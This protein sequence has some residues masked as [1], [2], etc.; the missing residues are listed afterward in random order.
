MNQLNPNVSTKE[1]DF[2]HV[3]QPIINLT[4]NTVHGYE[5]LIRSQHF[6]NPER[7][8]EYARQ[9]N[10]LAN[11][12]SGS[13]FEAFRTFMK[14][15][16]SINHLN[17]FVNIFPSTL[18]DSSFYSFLKK[19][20]SLMDMKT[21]HVVFEIN[22]A[23]K[24]TDFSAVKEGIQAIRNE[25]FRI[26]LDDIGKGESTLRAILEIQPDIAKIDRYFAGDLAM[27]PEK[28]KALKLMLMLFDNGTEVIVEGFECEDDLETAR[29]LG[30]VYGQGYFLGKPKPI[31][32]YMSVAYPT[33]YRKF[34]RLQ[35][36]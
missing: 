1:I 12:D 13:I 20:K 27:S 29:E 31:K 21:G 32:D 4:T 9:K 2:Y 25:G 15:S 23:E 14:G 34:W 8:F 28:Q 7:L 26:A 36:G 18:I 24:G 33:K 6:Q 10:Q 22:E 30:V 11:L 35:D 17:I 16:I 5:V 19:L 3:V